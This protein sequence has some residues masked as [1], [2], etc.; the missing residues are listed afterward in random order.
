VIFAVGDFTIKRVLRKD[1]MKDS[2]YNTY[3]YAGLPPGP[4]MMPSINAINSVLDYQHNDYLYM[5]AK[6]DFSGYHNFANN[7]ADHR[8]NARKFQEA[9]NQRHIYR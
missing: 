1:L 9:L 6:E 4:I 2:P 5:C 8:V 3:M 7:E